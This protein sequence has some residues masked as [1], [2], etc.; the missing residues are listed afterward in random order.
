MP[1]GVQPEQPERVGVHG[2]DQRLAH[3]ARLAGAEA[4]TGAGQPSG[5]LRP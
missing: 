1:C 4:G 3:R 5:E 2:P